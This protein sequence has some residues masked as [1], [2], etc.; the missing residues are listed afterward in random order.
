LILLSHVLLW[1]VGLFSAGLLLVLFL[2]RK[3]NIATAILSVGIPIAASGLILFGAGTFVRVNL[4]AANGEPIGFSRF[5]EDP[6]HLFAQIGLIT[7]IVGVVIIAAS[8][9]VRF[10]RRPS[11]TPS[12]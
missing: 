1:V 2:L 7:T 4:V 9:V 3:R 12:F 8:F 5:L 10:T 6:V 11:T